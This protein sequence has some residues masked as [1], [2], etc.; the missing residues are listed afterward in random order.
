[1]KS[2]LP[3][4]TF[5]AALLTVSTSTSCA[6]L[7]KASE[8]YITRAVETGAFDAIST[9][10]S[11]DVIYTQTT[12]ERS[13]ML[14]A[15]DNMIDD[16]RVKVEDATLKVGMKPNVNQCV[17]GEHGIEVRVSA[18]A[19]RRL[20][21]SSSGDIKLTNGLNATGDV[22]VV[23]GSSGDVIGGT[24]S[25]TGNVTLKTSSSG[26]IK[27]D[28]VSCKDFRTDASSS[29]DV[30]LGDVTCT[31]FRA[32]AS[33]SGD[34]E[35]RKVVCTDFWANAGSSGDME[36]DMLE[37]RNVFANAGS[38]G[39]I[40]LAGKCE[41]AD[42]SADSSGDIKASRLVVEKRLSKRENSGGSVVCGD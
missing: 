40:K 30:K 33:S 24:V 32:D 39:D 25:C 42:L 29:G 28:T 34:V 23:V 12:G 31:S 14:Y 13:I 19:V 4:L 38:T 11:V 6:N 41:N 9:S 8:N 21:A 15:P 7:K 37:A 35:I 2:F 22:Y 26:D 1:M 17:I 27:F 18:P 36:V 10:T 3:A 5:C 16:V 20:E